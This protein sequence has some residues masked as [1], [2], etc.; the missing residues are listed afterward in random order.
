MFVFL[1]ILKFHKLF[2]E[3]LNKYQACLYLLECIFN[4]DLTNSNK[5]QFL[6]IIL[7]IFV[8]FFDLSSAHACRVESVNLPH[9]NSVLPL[10]PDYY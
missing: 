7:M 8:L 3:L 4:G 2:H 6:F 10:A 1:K 9:E 5:I